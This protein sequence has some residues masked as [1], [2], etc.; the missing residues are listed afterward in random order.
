[1]SLFNNSVS[2]SAPSNIALVKYWGKRGM[3]LPQNPSI[4][5]TLENSKTTTKLSWK[6]RDKIETGYEFE[7]IFEGKKEDSFKEKVEIFF[8]RLIE[9]DRSCSFLKDYTLR[10]ESENS[11]PH[12]TGI[13]SSASGMSALALCLLSMKEKILGED[14]DRDTFFKI[15]SSMARVGSG[16]A[17]RS[18]YGE[19][20][21]WGDCFSSS[22]EVAAPFENTHPIFADYCD[23]ILIVS[24]EKKSVSST[25]GH[26]LMDGHPFAEVRFQNARKNLNKLATAL[27]TGDLHVFSEIV[28]SEALELHGLMM[29]STPSF[30]LM[31]PNTLNIIEKVRSFR[32]KSWIPL[33]FTLDAGPNVHLLYPKKNM[34]DVKAFILDELI[35]LCESGQVIHDRVGSGPQKLC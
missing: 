31:R 2:W 10:V 30:I 26:E 19:L 12:S 28:E 33:C 24:S 8:N 13:A 29:N 35:S 5:F 3:Q 23:S 4:S 6:R 20:V 21:T 32:Q 11:F 15:A 25:V 16:S 9:V 34:N 18:L 1:M 14:Y 17:S 22:N 7:F 27:K